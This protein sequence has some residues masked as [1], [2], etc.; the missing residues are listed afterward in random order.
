MNK[1]SRFIILVS[2]F[3]LAVVTVSCKCNREPDDMLN[4]NPEDVKSDEEL[5]SSIESVKQIFYSLP[6][7]LETAMILKRSGASYNE[8]LLNSIES[9]SKYN[10][11]KSM[12][13][14]LGIYSTDLS[15]ASLF[16][17]T[18][19]TIKYMTASKKMAEGLGILNAID[20]SVIEKLEENINNRDVILETISETFLN[21][22]SILQE[23]D[24]VAVGS[25]ILV[26][27]W[28]EGL[29]IATSLV[30][31]VNKV[32]NEMVDRIIDQKLSLGTVLK[33]LEQSISNADVKEL[34]DDMLE[35]QKVYNDI[36][37]EVKDVKVVN[38]GESNV[39]TIKSNNVT[40]ISPKSFENLKTKVKE[41]R[42]KY[43][44]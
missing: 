6:S 18:Q 12:A 33:L 10:T 43:T 16:D 31:D 20:N 19:A 38:S 28:V 23:D 32:D 9:V 13:L 39:S 26:G 15:Y 25:M 44:A 37:I 2:V 24:R 17:Q 36:K 41:L 22:N 11:T 5:I 14:N 40:S 35:L 8:E 21:T 1:G 27:G 30:D 4:V 7:P 42:N 3:A 29:Y 34:Y